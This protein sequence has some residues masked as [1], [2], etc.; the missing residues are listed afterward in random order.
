MV[1]WHWMNGNVTKE[2]IRKDLLWMHDIGLSGFFLFDA[3]YSTPQVVDT[4]LPYMSEGWKDAFRYAVNLADSLGLEVGIASSPGWSLTGGPWVSEDDAQK[5]LVW[6]TTPVSG[7]YRG[8]LP[9]P[10]ST[11]SSGL[12][13]AVPQQEG[14]VRDYLKEIRVLAVRQDSE[15]V[16][17]DISSFYGDGILDWNAPEG[18]WM[19]YRFAY[20]LIGTTN[21][22]APPEATGLEVDKLDAG[23]VRRY[24]DNYLGLYKE[25]LGRDLGP[26]SINNIDIDS[27]ESG[28]GTWTPRMEEEFEKRRG[29]SMALWL[30]A[31]AGEKIG[32]DEERERFLFDWRQTLGEL[33]A[34]NHY[35]LATEIFH[36]QGIKRYSESHEE[37]RSFM[38]DGMMVKRTADVPQGA[39]WVRFRAGV[40]AT[41]PHMEADLR[42]SSS[43]A[44]IYGQNICAAEAFTTNGRPGKWD[45]WWAYQCH[46][47][48]LKPVA[49]AAMAEGLNRFVIHTSVHQP[50][51]AFKPGLGLGPYGQWFNRYDTWASEARPW[52]DYISRSCFMLS[53]GRFVADIAY[54]YGEDTNLTQRFGQERPGIPAGWNYDFVNGDALVNALKIKDGK[55]VS[56]SG[57]SY[58]MLVVDN[59]IERMSDAV[60]ARIEA[61]REAG[62]PVCDLREGGKM[63][64]VLEKEGISPDVSDVPDSVAFV[65]RK[66][67]GGE[68]YWIA[69]I[70]S[71][72][73]NMTLGLRDYMSDGLVRRALEPKVWRA[74]RGTVEDVSYRIK[75]GRMLV[76][77]NL[78]RDDAVFVVLQGKAKQK[79]FVASAKTPVTEE[80][81]LSTDWA[82]HFVPAINP[83]E[84][85]D[86]HFDSLFAWN[87]SQDPFIRFFSGTATYRTSFRWNTDR[88]SAEAVLDL[89]QVCNMAHVYVNGKDL[90]LLWKEPYKIDI[91]G[92]LVEGDNTLEIKVTN[93][94]GNRLIGDSALPKEKR[95][96]KTSW[97]F[98]SPDDPL[99]VSGLLGPVRI[100]R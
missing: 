38:G 65:H 37:R 57:A 14:I 67:P 73:R 36:A 21:G 5:K 62:I 45:G 90:G 78:E 22:P 47:G 86:Y 55:M 46:P 39:F 49:D 27:Y 95:A 3:A 48:K 71:R 69:N 28:K 41:M 92:A 31:L 44:H 100:L 61:I 25:T 89:G 80:L 42:E 35:D 74:D 17:K 11:V 40:Y 87:E 79:S 23:A 81:L 54:L 63:L 82:V 12:F 94:W 33:L 53:Q 19:V 32:T 88:S 70:C 96:T 52:I 85:A 72:P 77:L 51:E 75:D 1:L 34:E 4:L 98:Y 13:H 97:E 66:L 7:H 9:L 29:Y 6:S 43:V 76:D 24:W 15:P 68:I 91:S 93:S 60:A 18:D 2:S 64:S 99:P 50:S 26:G 10:S 83:E 20:T 16:V 8:A 30:P 84:A 59:Q 56:K 58:R